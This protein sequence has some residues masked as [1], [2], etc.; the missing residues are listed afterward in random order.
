MCGLASPKLSDRL[1]LTRQELEAVQQ[2][3]VELAAKPPA[4]RSLHR[5]MSRKVAEGATPQ[6][7][8]ARHKVVKATEAA[9]ILNGFL[10]ALAELPIGQSVG[11]E[12][13][14]TPKHF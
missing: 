5:A 7:S 12:T 8:E 1:R 9:L 3:E 4:E 10:E 6:L 2:R 13:G 11:I 14:I